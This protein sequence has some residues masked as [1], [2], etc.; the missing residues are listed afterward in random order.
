MASSKTLM[1]NSMRYSS[2]YSIKAYGPKFFLRQNICSRRQVW[3]TFITT[4]MY[5][6]LKNTL[7]ISKPS[8]IKVAAYSFLRYCIMFAIIVRNS[9]AVLN[10][11]LGTGVTICDDEHD[12][13][14]IYAHRFVQFCVNPL[15]SHLPSSSQSGAINKLL[16]VCSRPTK[17]SFAFRG[18]VCVQF[19]CCKMFDILFYIVDV[20]VLDSRIYRQSFFLIDSSFWPSV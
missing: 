4:I 10:W 13:Y 6:I 8:W 12:L 9:I 17:P 15:R 16:K 20:T 2:W 3:S 11:Q 19:P 1:V 18:Q 14:I 5:S 7:T